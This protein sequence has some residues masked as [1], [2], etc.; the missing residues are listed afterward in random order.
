MLRLKFLLTFLILICI[1]IPMRL[2]YSTHPSNPTLNQTF[3]IAGSRYGVDWK[4]AKAVAIV[5]SELNPKAISHKGAIGIM[6]IHP[7][8]AYWYKI[9]KSLLFNLYINVH[10]GTSYLSLLTKR[11]GLGVG[12]QMYNLGETK[13]HNGM[14]SFGYYNRVLKEYRSQIR[15]WHIIS[16]AKI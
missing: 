3:Q 13:Y 15:V 4:L 7:S 9:N 5:E 11:Y 10:I 8:L 2:G 14:R 16:E 1:L 6:Q 12:L